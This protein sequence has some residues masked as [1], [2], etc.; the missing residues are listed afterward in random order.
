M[1]TDRL[2]ENIVNQ[3]SALTKRILSDR[4]ELVRLREENARLRRQNARYLDWFAAAR[5]K[6]ENYRQR[7]RDTRKQ[8]LLER[9]ARR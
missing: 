8:L 7:Y 4:D 9:E 3:E 6:R 1:N 5:R 2:I